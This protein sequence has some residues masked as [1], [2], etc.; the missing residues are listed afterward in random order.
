MIK[1]SLTLFAQDTPFLTYKSAHLPVPGDAILLK[2]QHY[3]V[4]A[5]EQKLIPDSFDES[6]GG[7]NT[8]WELLV[9]QV[10]TQNEQGMG[11]QE[12]R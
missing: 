3:I 9:R 10:H 4:L 5:R 1:I 6:S 12:Q 7:W 8:E 11:D 2:S